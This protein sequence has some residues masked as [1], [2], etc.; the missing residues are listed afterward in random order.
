MRLAKHYC[1]TVVTR[2]A[3]FFSQ[4][5]YQFIFPPRVFFYQSFHFHASSTATHKC[6]RYED[7][8]VVP[9]CFVFP[10]LLLILKFFCIFAIDVCWKLLVPI[11]C[12]LLYCLYFLKINFKSSKSQAF[13]DCVHVCMLSRFGYV[14][15]LCDPMDSS[16]PGSCVSG[17]LQAK[18]LEWVAMPSSSGSSRPR[19]E[20]NI[21]CSSWIAG[22]FFTTEPPGKPLYNSF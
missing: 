5:L 12:I 3:S 20:T 11:F 2:P 17:I 16:P 18:M 21:S 22:R 8:E 4:W 9:H 1:V 19:D 7:W 13:V 15:T 14:S 10:S 6:T